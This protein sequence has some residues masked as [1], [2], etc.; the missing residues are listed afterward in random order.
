[1]YIAS[2][3]RVL[4]RVGEEVQEVWRAPSQEVGGA[5]E[6]LSGPRP[7]DRPYQDSRG[8]EGAG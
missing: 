4:R 6:P 2:V 1:M 8:A 5:L 3:Y 7:A